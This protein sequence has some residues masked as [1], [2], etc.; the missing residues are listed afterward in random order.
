MPLKEVKDPDAGKGKS[1][2]TKTP[3]SDTDKAD[4]WKYLDDGSKVRQGRKLPFENQLRELFDAVAGGVAMADSFS[5]EVVNKQSEELAYGYAKLAKEDARVKAFFERVV[6]GSAY[7]AA[8]QPT[9][10]VAIPILWHFGLMPSKFG[11]PVTI[12]AG[13]MPFTREQERQYLR[14][15]QAEQEQA[16]ATEAKATHPHGEAP[17]DG[18]HSSS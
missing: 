18:D 17:G 2:K 12:A 9:V 8:I 15:Q 3:P 5:G 14:E 4:P 1:D 7:S 16:E 6:A 13:M 10:L 11:V